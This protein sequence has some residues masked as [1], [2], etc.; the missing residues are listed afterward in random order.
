MANASDTGKIETFYFFILIGLSKAVAYGVLLALA[1]F[2]LLPDYGRAS[3]V[4]SAFR[5]VVLFGTIGLPFIFVPWTI[6]KKDTSSL[7]YFLLFFNL[8]L[9]LGGLIVGLKY[10]WILP[11]V[12]VIP[13]MAISGISNSIL[14]VKHD[15]HIIQLLGLLLEVVTLIS[16]LIFAKYGKLGI[17]AGHAAA[18]YVVNFAFIY[19]TRKELWEMARVFNFKLKVIWNYLKKGTITTMLYL[20]FAFL[21]WIDSLVLGYL[22][23]FENVARYNV[24]G[25]ISNVLAIIPFSLSM[26]LLTR[27][28]EVKSK[29]RSKAI[30]RRSLR[31]SFVFSLLVAIFMLSL[32]FPLIKIFFPKYVGI[33]I[34]VTILSAGILFYSL[35]SLLYIYEAGKLEP[36]KAF[37]PIF[38]AAVIN[39]VLDVVLIPK[40]GLYGITVAT[41]IAHSFAFLTLSYKMHLLKEFLSV[42]PMLLFL[43]L[44]YNAGVMGVLLVPLALGLAYWFRL[45]K[46]GDLWSITQTIFQIFERFR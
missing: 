38:L 10:T 31:F 30:L 9:M 29:K 15:Y 44:S 7:F 45:L 26:F 20:S 43:P 46:E 17:I 42:F 22:S 16:L 2:F 36:E 6:N 18:F 3:F 32:I 21:N 27:E 4:M 39:I 34:Y 8:A 13:L 11:I 41:T 25:P 40:Y 37:W 33:E 28:S 24:A 23:T 12:F 14:R 19:L 5:A 35:Y 1:N